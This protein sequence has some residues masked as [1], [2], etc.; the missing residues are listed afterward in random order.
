M[1]FQGG[2]FQL[3][4]VPKLNTWIFLF[5]FLKSR[6]H[7]Q[8]LH[9]VTL[10]FQP[11]EIRSLQVFTSHF[12]TPFFHLQVFTSWCAKTSGFQLSRELLTRPSPKN[13]IFQ[14]PGW[15]PRDEGTQASLGTVI[16]DTTD[17]WLAKDC[18]LFSK[19]LRYIYCGIQ[20]MFQFFWKGCIA[21][22]HHNVFFFFVE[23]R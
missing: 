21:L 8:Q 23:L 13:P 16:K 9:L 17:L 18:F 15:A 2:N 3:R 19:A 4:P 7:Y 12:F 5:M 10:M 14:G 11:P 22:Q 20:Y 6:M 1:G